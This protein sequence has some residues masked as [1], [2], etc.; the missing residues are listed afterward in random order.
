METYGV[1]AEQAADYGK[2]VNANTAASLAANHWAAA[3][4]PLVELD[5]VSGC[6]R[7]R[8]PPPPDTTVSH[9]FVTDKDGRI[10]IGILGDL[11]LSVTVHDAAGE[12]A[13][14]AYGYVPGGRVIYDKLDGAGV[15]QPFLSLGFPFIC[16][17]NSLYISTTK[18]GVRVTAVF[19]H[20]DWGSRVAMY[21]ED[22]PECKV[23]HRD[24]SIYIAHGRGNEGYSINYLGKLSQGATDM[25]VICARIGCKFVNGQLCG[26]NGDVV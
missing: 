19:G 24:G 17:R 7:Y 12:S 10:D 20:L 26:S 5:K 2:R 18:P 13:M 3:N 9:D 21:G 22:S 16:V 4:G 14:W 23:A 6:F 11:L 15:M 25:E 8:H 1:V